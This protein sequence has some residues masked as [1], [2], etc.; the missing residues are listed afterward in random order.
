MSNRHQWTADQLEYMRFLATPTMAREEI[1]GVKM[2]TDY[3]E[4]VMKKSR[5][6][7]WKW[8]K[9]PGFMDEVGNMA[10]SETNDKVADLIE[11]IFNEAINKRSVGAMRLASEIAFDLL[12]KQKV[13]TVDTTNE[14]F[15]KITDEEIEHKIAELVERINGVSS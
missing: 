5:A 13:E 7:T 2:K 10:R 3:V 12:N 11:V 15:D 14:R 9:I 8:E 1:Y 4:K 6:T